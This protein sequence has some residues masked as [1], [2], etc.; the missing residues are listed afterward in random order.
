MNTFKAPASGGV[1][2]LAPALPG[3]MEVF[4]LA[5]EHLMVQS[6]GFIASSPSFSLID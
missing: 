5:K 4:D 6:G 2:R 1:V 3:D